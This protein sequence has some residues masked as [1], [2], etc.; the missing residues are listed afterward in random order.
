MVA[1]DTKLGRLEAAFAPK[2]TPIDSG[3]HLPEPAGSL[4][5]HAATIRVHIVARA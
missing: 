1:G 3:R 5:P 2:N 4:E